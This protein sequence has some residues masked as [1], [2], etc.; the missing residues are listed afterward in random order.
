MPKTQI[1]KLAYSAKSAN[2]TVYRGAKSDGTSLLI[3]LFIH[4]FKI[5]TFIILAIKK[6]PFIVRVICSTLAAAKTVLNVATNGNNFVPIL[7]VLIHNLQMAHDTAPLFHRNWL[8]TFV[9]FQ[10]DFTQ[11]PCFHSPPKTENLLD[12]CH[13]RYCRCFFGPLFHDLLQ[14]PG[15][16]LWSS[17]QN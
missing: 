4:V 10:N 16:T 3:Y 1:S 14:R 5:S 17:S 15:S 11:P 9:L 12:Q 13:L 6:V 2:H 8:S 7:S